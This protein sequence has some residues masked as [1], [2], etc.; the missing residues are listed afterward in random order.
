MSPLGVVISN[1]RNVSSSETR[2]NA[3]IKDGSCT[4]LNHRYV[5]N[6]SVV[7][8]TPLSEKQLLNGPVYRI[9]RFEATSQTQYFSKC[10]SCLNG[11]DFYFL[12][13]GG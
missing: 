4:Y 6:L 8:V 12:F 2:I 11:L 3:G 7:S 13:F 1:H 9:W 10:I 5:K